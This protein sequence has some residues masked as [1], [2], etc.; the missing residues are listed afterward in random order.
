MASQ[1]ET[2]LQ[3][4]RTEFEELIHAIEQRK[5]VFFVG[6]GISRYSPTDID[7]AK[8][9]SQRFKEK[10]GNYPWWQEYFDR[11]RLTSEQQSK[12]LYTNPDDLPKLEEIA[13]LFLSRNEF[14]QFIDTIVEDGR[15]QTVPPNVCHTVLSELLIEEICSGVITTNQDDRIE[16][17]HRE[18]THPGI[19]PNIVSHDY[20]RQNWRQNNN[21]FKIH[22]CLSF[23]P[24]RKYQSIWATSQF[25]G[26]TWPS[27]VSFA[28]E[29]LMHFGQGVYKIVF[30]GFSTNLQYLEN[31]IDEIV[32]NGGNYNQFYCVSRRSLSEIISKQENEKFVSS[33]ELQNGRH[34]KMDAETFFQI[35]RYIAFENLLNDL[36]R[37]NTYLKGDEF[38]GGSIGYLKIAL[39]EFQGIKELLKKDVLSTDRENFQKFLQLILLEKNSQNKYVSF[40]Y[41]GDHI[42]QLFFMLA[43]LRFN[44]TLVF[45]QTKYRHLF[46]KKNG[47]EISLIIINGGRKSPLQAILQKLNDEIGKDYEMARDVKNIFIYNALDDALPV[48]APPGS[49]KTGR[50]IE[51]ERPIGTIKNASDYNYHLLYE[52]QLRGILSASSTLEEFNR[53]LGGLPWSI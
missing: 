34:Y 48:D 39:A 4:F 53:K 37:N 26:S 7:T 32:H 11:N 18:I 6:A 3:D 21:V 12:R 44:Y 51:T 28:H 42:A 41:K 24:T 31:T 43:L 25:T 33:I 49:L 27:G 1:F 13:D 35:V 8:E 10:F 30:V 22:G 15:W 23:C 50:M 46:I 5:I 29:V 20:F 38:K 14:N 19:A 17:K 9:L 40:R 36:S 2:Q 47:C 52:N 45:C 16:I